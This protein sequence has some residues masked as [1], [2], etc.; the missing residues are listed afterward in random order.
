MKRAHQMRIN[1]VLHPNHGILSLKGLLL[2]RGRKTDA[3][4]RLKWTPKREPVAFCILFG[5]GRV[6]WAISRGVGG[7]LDARIPGQSTALRDV[8]DEGRSISSRRR[9]MP[10]SSGST[11]FRLARDVPTPAISRTWMALWPPAS[12][13]HEMG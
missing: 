4:N 1:C 2:Q 5:E 9:R 10:Q 7:L 6:P 13:S 3:P 12:A 8:E 11:F